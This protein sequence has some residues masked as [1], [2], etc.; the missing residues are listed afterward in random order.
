LRDHP[1]RWWSAPQGKRANAHACDGRRMPWL[2]RASPWQNCLRVMGDDSIP[3]VVGEN[4]DDDRFVSG[5]AELIA[6]AAWADG[7]CKAL[8][9]HRERRRKPHTAAAAANN[10][11][12]LPLPRALPTWHAHPLTDSGS[13]HVPGEFISEVGEPS[14]PPTPLSPTPL[15]QGSLGVE[16]PGITHCNAPSMQT[17]SPRPHV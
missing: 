13:C 8:I 6:I 12:R 4:T 3:T 11:H 16:A 15:S 1:G 14:C 5:V 2:P 17:V 7:S 9:A 10:P